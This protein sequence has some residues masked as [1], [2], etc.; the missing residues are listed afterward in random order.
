[1][2]R[3]LKPEVIIISTIFMALVAIILLMLPKDIYI[4]KFEPLVRIG[5]NSEEKIDKVKMCYGSRYFHGEGSCQDISKNI[6]VTGK[7]DNK[8][9]GNYVLVYSI[10]YKGIKRTLNQ[11][12]QV[13][14]NEKPEID[15][16]GVE[17]VSKCPN[18]KISE[19][20]FKA[21]DKQDGDLTK[22]V[23]RKIEKD[24]YVYTVTDSAGNKA[25]ATRSILEGDLIPP[26]I[27]LKSG[28]E[29]KIA[30]NEKYIELG[31]IVTD[32]CVDDLSSKVTIEGTV[33]SSVEGVYFLTYLVTD[34]SN[35]QA[36]IVRKV[37]V[38]NPKEQPAQKVVYLTFD[39]GPGIYTG[40][41]L[42]VLKKYDVKA[43]F[44]VTAQF[45]NYLPIL[46]RIHEEGHSIGVHSYSHVFKNIYASED[47]FFADIDKINAIIKE[48]TGQHSRLLRFAGGGSNRVSKFNPGIMTRLAK[49]VTENGYAYFDWNVDS[50]DT[51]LTSPDKIANKVIEQLKY[52]SLF[53]IVLQHDIKVANIKS[54]EKIIEFGLKNNY[55]FKPLTVN[56]PTV[57]HQINN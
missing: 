11:T 56:S 10:D 40:Q 54:V 19:S 16:L 29:I 5:L 25:E 45:K 41:I 8:K 23:K 46:K 4:V 57:H 32:N 31:Y 48:H 24:K 26:I 55:V 30:L 7:I 44:F 28:N 13:Y 18:G 22:K 38:G 21:S 33:D 49:K 9:I 42:D 6:T 27:E 52:K 53:Y 36:S 39:D 20:E 47:N 50:N 15:F 14:D 34:E 2:R 12:I 3:T 37:I 35:N 17:V 51:S 1:M 43:T